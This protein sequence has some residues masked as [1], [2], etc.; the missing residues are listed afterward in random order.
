VTTR[1]QAASRQCHT[2]GRPILLRQACHACGSHH[3]LPI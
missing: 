2:H 1:K 3:A